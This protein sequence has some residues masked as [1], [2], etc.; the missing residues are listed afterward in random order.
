MIIFK[1]VTCQRITSKKGLDLD[2]SIPEPTIRS[3]DTGQRIPYVARLSLVPGTD[4]MSCLS[5][6][7]LLCR[8]L[9]TAVGPRMLDEHVD[10][11]IFLRIL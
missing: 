1:P 11:F 10:A 7:S 4:C 9:L 3:G 8:G 5:P 2:G 6:F